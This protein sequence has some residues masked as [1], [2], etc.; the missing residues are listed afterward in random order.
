MRLIVVK[1]GTNVLAREDQLLDVTGISRLVDQLAELK[2]LGVE[3]LL[4]SSGAVGAGRSM[5]PAP[6]G[7]SRVVRRQV[8]AAIGQV[9]LMELYR[10]LFSNYGLFCAQVLATKEDFRDRQHYLNMKNCLQA[11]LRDNIVPVVNENDVVAIDELMFTDNDELAG[12]VAAMTNAEAL[13]ILSSVDGFLDGPP[14][15]P[16]SKVIPEIDPNEKKWLDFILPSR[17]SFGRGGMHTKFRI[18]QKAANV[19]IHTIIANGKRPGILLDIFNGTFTGTRFVAKGPVSGIKKWLAYNELERKG[20][21]F[22]NEGA[23]QAIT[24]DER[25]SSLLPVGIVRVEGEFEKGDLV[26]ILDEKGEEIGLGVAQYGAE[27]A[28]EHMGQKGKK[29]LIHYDYLFVSFKK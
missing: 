13:I 11:L 8:L 15:D 27:T 22:I 10:Q 17:S 18:A 29:E 20:K 25:I 4:V 9:K 12:L 28:R 6:Q 5:M 2:R 16:S 3:V 24:S 26:R 7:M 1:V 19:G 14:E 23:V 21:V